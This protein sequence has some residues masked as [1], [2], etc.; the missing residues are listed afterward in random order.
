MCSHTYNGIEASKTGVLG[1]YTKK[2]RYT[3]GHQKQK[4]KM[5][6]LYIF[7]ICALNY[8]VFFN[9]LYLSLQNKTEK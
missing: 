5:A 7:I 9:L 6:I 8:F 1:N 2:R 4:A 3:P